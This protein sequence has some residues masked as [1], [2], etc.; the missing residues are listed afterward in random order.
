MTSRSLDADSK[1]VSSRRSKKKSSACKETKTT[2]TYD[3]NKNDGA[4][5]IFEQS[6]K[7]MRLK[8]FLNIY[9]LNLII[10]KSLQ[11]KSLIYI[12]KLI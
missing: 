11:N 12:S 9:F 1:N 10:A 7:K 5:W 6:Q 4:F 2:E 3:C 8:M